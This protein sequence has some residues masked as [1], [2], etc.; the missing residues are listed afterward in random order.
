MKIL[1]PVSGSANSLSAVRH[2]AERLRAS[3]GE[4]LMVNV[5]P[6]LTSHAARFTSRSTRDAMRAERS[7]RALS[8][9]R[10]LAKSLG[11]QWKTMTATGPLAQTVV[12][13]AREL[14]ADQVVL[15]AR[16]HAGWW[17]AL[18]SPVA[19]ILD[20]SEM[21]VV[22]VNASRSSSVFERYGVP[23]GVGLG[24]TALI[25]TAE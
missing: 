25:M 12:E 17:Q 21:P 11:V 13:L 15:G 4:L 22:V 18:V 19:R 24:L 5:Q 1:V 6:R 8:A 9:A 3:G 16:Q 2:A 10:E 23:A 7:E 14:R 20:R